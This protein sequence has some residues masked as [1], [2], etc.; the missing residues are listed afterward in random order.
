MLRHISTLWMPPTS[1]ANRITRDLLLSPLRLLV[2]RRKSWVRDCS[3]ITSQNFSDFLAK[4][5]AEKILRRKGKLQWP[6]RWAPSI[7]MN[8]CR[9][10]CGHWGTLKDYLYIPLS[11]RINC[12]RKLAAQYPS[13]S[14]LQV[15]WRYFHPQPGGQRWA[16]Y[17]GRERASKNSIYRL[18]Y[19]GLC[20]TRLCRFGKSFSPSF[21][22]NFLLLFLRTSFLLS[23]QSRTLFFLIF[24]HT[25]FAKRTQAKTWCE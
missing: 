9:Q 11:M 17:V 6:R 16:Q 19:L 20:A 2:S 24:R 7:R 22:G 21:I 8:S 25:R 15:W 10:K 3:S 5:R 18:L 23:F 14:A 13:F 12:R 4:C 1:K